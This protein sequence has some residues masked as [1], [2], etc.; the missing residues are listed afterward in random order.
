MP[1]SQQKL[2][3][4]RLAATLSAA[5]LLGG[6]AVGP[7]YLRPSFWFPEPAKENVA[8]ARAEAPINPQW[9]TLFGDSA[10]NNLEQQAVAA[11][12]D[13]QAAIARLEA[14]EAA[15]RE[16]GA[17]YLP[18]L[19]LG[20]SSGRSQASG[21]TFNGQ[22]TGGQATYNNTRVAASLSYEIDLWGRVRRN[23]EAARAE[24]L[25]SRFGRDAVG[26]T[27][28]GQVANEYLN[29]RGL[30][31][32]LAVTRDTL[33]SREK[34]LKIVNARLDAGSASALDQAQAAGALAAA[35]A[36]WNQLQ[37]Q[38]ALSES[39]LALL[40]GQPGL[41]IAA[42][43][44]DKLPLPPTPPAGLPSELLEARPDVRQ[45]EEKLIAANARIGVAKAAYF[46]S[47]S[48]TG[49]YG[50]ESMA[51]ANLFS[52][53]STLWSAALGLSMPIFDAGRTGARVDQASAAQKE[54]LANYRKTVQTAFKEVNDALVGLREY[55]GE[56]TANQAQVTATRRALE[57]SQTRYEAGYAGFSDV[58]DA[59][60]TSNN[61]QLQYLTSRKNRLGA[62]VDLFKA[63]GGGWQASGS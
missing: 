28:A 53:G 63:L 11:N 26:L 58:L 30:D 52:G 21:T 47:I 33:T 17:D 10:L 8:V 32:Q 60:R 36:Q 62:A 55:A 48:L 18:A 14:A 22:K 59:Q 1:A 43:D 34:S 29:L 45:S 61:A 27:L 2:P 9:W 35:Q 19:S 7:D 31:A 42:A 25:A 40:T 46:P 38:R 3:V 23:N 24:A 5:L 12:Q 54:A 50:S 39:Q 20:A 13:L 51:L 56:E 41:K 6:C 44:L 37:R 16:A 49:L 15:A 57:L 4:T